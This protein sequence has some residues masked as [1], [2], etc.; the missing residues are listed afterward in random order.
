[1]AETEPQIQQTD[2]VWGASA[3]A[4]EVGLD[5]SALY[6]L[7]SHRLIPPQR[8]GRRWVASRTR[9]RQALTGDRGSE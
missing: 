2:I 1:M 8:I 7:L 4:R 9:L 3:I 6:H 5:R